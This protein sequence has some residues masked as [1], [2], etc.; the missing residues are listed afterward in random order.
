[1]P[2]NDYAPELLCALQNAAA[3]GARL[4]SICTGAFVLAE[5]GLLDGRTVTTHWRYADELSAAH[6]Q[7]RVRPEVLF[8]KDGPIV[9]S[10]GLAA[11]IDL[12]LHLIRSDHGAA[13]ANTVA[14]LAVVGA[15]PTR[16]ASP[17]HRRSRCFT[18]LH[19]F[20]AHARMGTE[21]IAGHAHVGR[22]G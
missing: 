13:V 16:W 21:Q 1:V 19:N 10:A 14:R 17:V 4:A 20:G 5:A 18:G 3:R 12:C 15:R 6:P 2:R 22:L 7:V 8:V 9:T 11:G